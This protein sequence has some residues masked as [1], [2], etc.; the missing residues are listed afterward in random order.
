MQLNQDQIASYHDQGFLFLPQCFS[1]AEM[2]VVGAEVRRVVDEDSPGRLLET[3]GRTVRAVHGCHATSSLM[4]RLVR[5]PRLLEP[6]RQVLGTEVYTHQFKINLKAAFG[7][8]V[9]KW[10]QDFI[11]WNKQDGVAEPLLFNAAV[12]CDDVNEFNGPLYLLAGS[13]KRGMID[14]PAGAGDGDWAASFAANLR[15]TVP[16][17][18]IADMVRDGGI[19]A[20]KGPAG[21]VL[22]FHPNLAHGS[23]PNISPFGRTLL[24]ATY[25]SVDNEPVPVPEPRPE[26]L[27]SRDYT[28][29]VPVRDDDLVSRVAM[30]TLS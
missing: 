11:F 23:V 17:S 27:I 20:P 25:N 22:L 1:P 6:A 5:H 14:V 15:Y 4:A 29:L 16:P 19:V 24:I 2:S 3:D 26:F 30:P 12:F 9:W 10:H 7:G 28:P 13:H 21:S 18:V 8:D